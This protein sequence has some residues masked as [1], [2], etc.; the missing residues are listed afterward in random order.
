[1]KVI[2]VAGPF[3]GANSWEMEQ[4][5]RRAEELSLAVW[6][7]G[8][9]ALCPHTNTRFFQGAAPDKVWIDG[10]LELLRRCDAVVL[11]ADWIRSTGA[12]GE[13]R[14]A[15]ARGIPVYGN[16]H[17]LEIGTRLNPEWLTL[18]MEEHEALLAIQSLHS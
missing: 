9:A 7:A 4:N 11:T 2:Y 5:I 18:N 13:V 14:E 12:R 10:T 16:V 17:E 6:R 8:F 1:M 15:I 3:R